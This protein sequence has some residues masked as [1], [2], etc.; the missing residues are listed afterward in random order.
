MSDPGYNEREDRDGNTHQ[1]WY[2]DNDR[3]SQDRDKNGNVSNRHFS[4]NG[5]YQQNDPFEVDDLF[6]SIDSIFTQNPWD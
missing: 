4:N 1:T 3:Y 6:D 2:D 5:G